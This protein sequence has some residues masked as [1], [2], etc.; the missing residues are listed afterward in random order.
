M[1]V[2]N[3]YILIIV[4]RRDVILLLK[5]VFS[6]LTVA[7]RFEPA[8]A[9]FFATEVMRFSTFFSILP[10][11]FVKPNISLFIGYISFTLAVY[12]LLTGSV[13]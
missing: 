5:T 7:M 9:K 2:K 11:K 13:F 8:N 10:W 1:P 6:T 12:V 4:S 3:M